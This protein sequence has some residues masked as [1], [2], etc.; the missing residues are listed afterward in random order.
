MDANPGSMTKK[1]I[2]AVI[3]LFT[4]LLITDDAEITP[5][6]VKKLMPLSR[7]PEF[8]DLI[9]KAIKLGQDDTNPNQ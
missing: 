5:A 6:Q 1:S 7:M 9:T 4:A 8:S 2:G 3:D